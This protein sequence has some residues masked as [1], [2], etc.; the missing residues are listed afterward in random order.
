MGSD[1]ILDAVDELRQVVSD[2]KLIVYGDEKSRINGLLIDFGELRRDV[3]MIKGDVSRLKA[4]RPSV[5]LWVMGYCSFL[6]GTGFGVV[7]ILNQIDNHNVFDMP[8]PAAAFLAGMFVVV[9]LFLFM[10][11]FGWFDDNR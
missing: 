11:G 8:A 1:N 7:A 2:L 9:A 3:A 5:W 6:V 10:A 4:R